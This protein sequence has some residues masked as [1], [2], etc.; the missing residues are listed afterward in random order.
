MAKLVGFAGM[1]RSGKD[2]T[3][4]LLQ[5]SLVQ[6]GKKVGRDSFAAPL[7]AA[8]CDLFKLTPD[9][10]EEWKEVYVHT[11]LPMSQLLDIFNVFAER[12]R[13]SVDPLLWEEDLTGEDL[14]EQLINTD[15]GRKVD[16]SIKTIGQEVPLVSIVGTPRE[17]MQ[18]FGTEVMRAI[19][20]QFWPK[21]LISRVSE[22]DL[23]YVFITDV[24]FD[25]EEVVIR[26]MGGDI[27]GIDRGQPLEDLHASEVCIS[28]IVKRANFKV[29]NKA[30]G[31][32]SL[33]EQVEEIASKL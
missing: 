2:T 27:I 32:D 14:Y 7:R 25:N 3:A 31:F 10:L 28:G 30:L 16:I 21:W 6:R 1:K 22:N 33:K 9:Q 13:E 8:A 20:D 11:T 5:S 24:R 15:W 12:A 29:D 18:Y 17:F 4:S 19:D 23:D 26:A